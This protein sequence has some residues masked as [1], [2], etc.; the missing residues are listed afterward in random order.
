MLRREKTTQVR[1][2]A[3]HR[4]TTVIITRHYD[5]QSDTSQAEAT[6]H[7]QLDRLLSLQTDK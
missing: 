3:P 1:L 2:H 7:D 6:G 4:I 5:Q